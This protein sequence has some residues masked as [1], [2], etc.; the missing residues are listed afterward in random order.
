M[1]REGHGQEGEGDKQGWTGRD[2]GGGGVCEMEET[3]EVTK[4]V[5]GMRYMCSDKSRLKKGKNKITYTSN[6]VKS[7]RHET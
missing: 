2:A 1:Q 7:G 3:G 6:S 5:G 4:S